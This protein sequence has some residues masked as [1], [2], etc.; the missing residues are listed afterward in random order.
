M[1]QHPAIG[2]VI[3]RLENRTE[4]VEELMGISGEVDMAQLEK[5]CHDLVDFASFLA[6]EAYYNGASEAVHESNQE[7]LDITI[8][9]LR[10]IAL[11]LPLIEGGS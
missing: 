8:E 4:D 1:H 5:A 10:G 3:A 11:R 2:I 9:Y 7:Q 6:I